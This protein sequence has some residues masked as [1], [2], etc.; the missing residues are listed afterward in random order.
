V[1]AGRRTCEPASSPGR[2]DQAGTAGGCRNLAS[3]PTDRFAGQ[4]FGVSRLGPGPRT[5]DPGPLTL[6]SAVSP[7]AVRPQALSTVSLPIR[8]GCM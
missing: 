3:M 4:H 7:Q 2:A 8:A 5:Q 1:A 6:R